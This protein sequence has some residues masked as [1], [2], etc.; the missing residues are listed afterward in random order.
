MLPDPLLPHV[1]HRGA[2]LA[3]QRPVRN[4]HRRAANEQH[5]QEANVPR[6]TAAGAILGPPHRTRHHSH[7][8]VFRSRRVGSVAE[9]QR[10]IKLHAPGCGLGKRLVLRRRLSD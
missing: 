8:R 9:K 1:R 10:C 5:L 7:R 3:T 6:Q 2:G 4:E